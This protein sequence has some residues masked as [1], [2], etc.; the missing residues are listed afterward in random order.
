VIEPKFIERLLPRVSTVDVVSRRVEL[1]RR[2]YKHLGSLPIPSRTPSFYVYPDHS[3]CYGCG[4][5][6]DVIGFV[7][8][9]E[10]LAS[11]MPRCDSPP[12]WDSSR[13]KD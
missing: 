1:K 7:M 5:H 8:R 9:T 11:P 4:A 12:R 2:E 6:S 13:V 10:G 3:H